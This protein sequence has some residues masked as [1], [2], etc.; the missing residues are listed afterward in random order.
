MASSTPFTI[1][2]EKLD[3]CLTIM[4]IS[5]LH[6]HE[7]V[8]AKMLDKLA[9]AIKAD[10][11]VRHPVIVDKHS[12]VVLDGMHRVSALE[13]LGCKRIPVCLV[14][15]AND[16]IKI[17]CWYRTINGLDAFNKTLQ[18]A[19]VMGLQHEETREIQKDML[20]TPPYMAALTDRQ[21][22]ILLKTSFRDKKEA[23]DTLKKIEE[24]A[25]QAG[26]T[27]EH[28]TE[29]DA[30]DKLQNKSADAVL[31]TPKLT[32]EDIV[33]TALAGRVY[34]YKATRH[35][36]P[37][38]PL[39]VNVPLDMLCND[40]TPLEKINTMLRAMLEKRRLKRVAGGSVFENRRYEED[41]YIF[42]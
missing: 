34:A 5:S 3:L 36:I 18:I 22:K 27:V 39:N 38:R 19:I 4:D 13:N 37:A 11:V 6:L 7:E 29:F 40:E 42:E 15:Y 2:H 9:D 14:D 28:E 35:V 12:Y 1:R 16:S 31:L 26:L 32:K 21:N 25:K 41:I 10:G 23:Y 33:Q 8:I 30:L 24:S 20:G 17:G